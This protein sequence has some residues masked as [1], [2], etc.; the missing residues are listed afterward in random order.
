MEFEI[1]EKE[2]I[3]N[4]VSTL[5]KVKVFKKQ[6]TPPPGSMYISDTKDLSVSSY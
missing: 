6:E 5:F 4:G 3:I 2:V 1:I